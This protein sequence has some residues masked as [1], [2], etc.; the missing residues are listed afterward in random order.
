MY[1][2]HITHKAFLACTIIG[3]IPSVLGRLLC[4]SQHSPLPCIHGFPLH[5]QSQ[6]DKES[7][8]LV[9][10][11]ADLIIHDRM[12]KVYSESSLL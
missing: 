10:M 3:S 2:K 12:V 11:S 1:N 7:M 4:P 5:R 6:A 9:I 8:G